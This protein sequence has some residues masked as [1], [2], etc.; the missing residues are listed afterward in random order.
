MDRSAFAPIDSVAHIWRHN[1]ELQD[2]AFR[3]L[4]L[5]DDA[6]CYPSSFKIEHLAQATI[7]LSALSAALI[8][9]VRHDCAVPKVVVLAEHACVEFK[10]E[11]LY[12]I[13]SKPA[14]SGNTRRTPQN[15]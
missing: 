12:T 1:L 6:G 10:S 3:A 8:W 5:S 7:T 15:L 9:S 11:R 14:S 4:E 2:A 13:N